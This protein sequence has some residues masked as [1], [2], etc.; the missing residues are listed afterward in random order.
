MDQQLN[1]RLNAAT[2]SAVGRFIYK[3]IMPATFA[4]LTWFGIREITS[5]DTSIDELQAASKEQSTAQN[6]TRGE[7][8]AIRD[9]MDYQNKYQTLVDQQ[10]NLELARHARELKLQ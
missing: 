3:F 5:L 1:D 7:V 2:D 8:R 9:Q 6:E 4:L 10:Q